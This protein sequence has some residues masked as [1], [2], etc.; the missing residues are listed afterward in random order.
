MLLE[1]LLCSCSF[2]RTAR[3]F[4]LLSFPHVAAAWPILVPVVLAYLVSCDVSPTLKQPI[5]LSTEHG[6][7]HALST[8][9]NARCML[10]AAHC[11]LHISHLTSKSSQPN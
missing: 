6:T 10:H 1:V 7:E 3:P 11:T 8:L 5:S 4:P 9:R 2:P